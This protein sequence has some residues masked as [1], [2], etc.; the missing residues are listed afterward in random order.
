MLTVDKSSDEDM[1]AR[2]KYWD[3]RGRSDL[4]DKIRSKLKPPERREEIAAPTITSRA[5]MPIRPVANA[6]VAVRKPDVVPPENHDVKLSGPA[7]DEGVQYWESRGR[8]DLAEQLRQRLKK[9]PVKKPASQGR[10][11]ERAPDNQGAVRTALEDSLLKN[12]NSLKT[13][14]D[15]AQLYRAAG[16]MPKARLQI[17]SLLSLSPDLPEALFASAQLYADQR[18]WLDAMHTLERVSPAS[19]TAEM[20]RLQKMCWAHLQLERADALVRQGKNQEAEILLRQ[21]AIELAVNY[22]QEK[23]P[24]PPALWKS[25]APK[26]K[27]SRR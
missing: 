7:L 1:M 3:K 21:V 8:G 22:N 27:S 10:E 4:A 16:E 26:A 6:I 23:M 11:V 5:E 17:E 15:L 2:A 13:R 24:E 18:L 25:D 19:R 14:L 9:E 12:P 20:G